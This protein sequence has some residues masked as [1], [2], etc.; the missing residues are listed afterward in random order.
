ME[1]ICKAL[2]KYMLTTTP[3]LHIIILKFMLIYF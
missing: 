2:A 1:D 3:D